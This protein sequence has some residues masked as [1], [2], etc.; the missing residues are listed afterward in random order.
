[1]QQ[2]ETDHTIKVDLPRKEEDLE[3][4]ATNAKTSYEKAKA[5]MPRTIEQKQLELAA[6]GRAYKRAATDLAQLEADA[7]NLVI[8]APV[9]GRFYYGA[10]KDGQW[11]KK[12]VV[13]ALV[14]GGAAP[15]NKPFAMVVPKDAK[16]YFTARLDQAAVRDLAP[17][18]KGEIRVKG[19]EDKPLQATVKSVAS[20]PGPD[21]RFLVELDAPVPADLPVL[22][23][24][25]AKASI[26]VYKSEKA[27]VVPAKA[28][29]ENPYRVEVRLADGG[30]E[31]R[32]VKTGRR[33]GDE[34]EI[35]SGLEAGQAIV[36]PD[37]K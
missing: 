16:L 12:D 17:G 9:A 11:E 6:A 5:E 32:E 13:K 7:K 28:L 29:R 24:M 27:L 15:V 3:R 8:K 10:F 37:K 18:R 25:S 19:F 14:K 30:T 22:P 35:L 2:L 33:K 31:L 34:V 26:P 4:T 36:V 20:V 21:G 1:M 23:G